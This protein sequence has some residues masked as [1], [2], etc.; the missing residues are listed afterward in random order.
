[1]LHV[2]RPKIFLAAL[3]GAAAVNV[4]EH[5][6]LREQFGKGLVHLDQALGLGI[7]R[8]LDPNITHHLGPKAGVQQVEDGM[9]N[10]AD[11][12]VH[13]HPVVGTVGHHLV[14]VGGVA[15][16]HEIP[17]R[18]DK[19]VHGVGLAARGFAAHRT[20]H[21]LA[22]PRTGRMKAFMFDQGV[23]RTIG[24]AVL[25]QHH[26]QV[27]FGHRHRAVFVAMDDGYG[28]APVALAADAPVTQTP[29]GFFLAQALG[30]K[31]FSNRV[32][33]SFKAQ[34]VQRTGIDANTRLGGIP[35]LPAR[36]VKKDSIR[37]RCAGCRFRLAV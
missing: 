4:V 21:A 16:P 34:A 13:R 14:G 2:V 33:G 18:I 31:K 6:A 32:H 28:R 22:A 19:R 12:L 1:M 24:N 30:C 36:V 7:F 15:V 37:D 35:V 11:V 27:F 9:F 23:A 3:L 26:R 10:A 20:G 5:H 25:R 8:A 17:R 29:G